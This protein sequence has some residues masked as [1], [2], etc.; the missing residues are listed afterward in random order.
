MGGPVG[1]P[2]TLLG[3][4]PPPIPASRP[5]GPA[6]ARAGAE[7]ARYRTSGT[8]GAYGNRASPPPATSGPT[9]LLMSEPAHWIA[10]RAY[11]G[12][13]RRDAASIR[14][15]SEPEM[16]THLLAEGEAGNNGPPTESR[17]P[18]GRAGRD[19]GRDASHCV[20]SPSCAT[21]RGRAQ[22]GSTNGLPVD[23]EVSGTPGKPR[24]PRGQEARVRRV[25][26]RP[27][28]PPSPS[29]SPLCAR[30]LQ[31]TAGVL[32]RSGTA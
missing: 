24:G 13:R 27:R 23:T 25:P 5:V 22:A 19:G 1:R 15:K 17:G 20:T 16:R 10:Q 11:G 2:P 29:T 8:F 31:S 7:T 26:L 28:S 18:E 4:S 6:G 12:R 21:G 9:A 32:A 3:G 14:P 30:S